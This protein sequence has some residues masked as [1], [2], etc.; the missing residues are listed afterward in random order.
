MPLPPLPG[1]E[2][3]VRA[4]FVDRW[5]TLLELPE[6]GHVRNFEEVR[7]VPGAIDALF[8]AQQAGWRVYLIGNEDAVAHGHLPD[9]AWASL[10]ARLLEHLSRLGVH[11]RR[12]YACLD[13]PEGRP[14]HR[15]PSVF[16]LPD[17]G[18]LYH[19]AQSDGVELRVSWVVGDSTL[20]LSA[21]ERAGCHVAGVR[22]GLGMGDGRLEV[23]PSFVAASLTSVV[24]TLLGAER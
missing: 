21:G 8:R 2:P 5:G 4:L 15:K 23:E 22:T 19:A 1:T 13:H 20:E 7:F 11:V 12:N 17:T 16:L 9:S 6:Q 14:P 3:P 10:E 24:D 18:L